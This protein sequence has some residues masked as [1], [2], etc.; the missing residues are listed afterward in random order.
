MERERREGMEGQVRKGGRREKRGRK[1]AGKGE[2][3]G[4][5]TEKSVS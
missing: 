2:K 1:G 4:G 5:E 3:E